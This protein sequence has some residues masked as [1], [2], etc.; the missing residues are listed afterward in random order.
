[1]DTT[2]TIMAVVL[3]GAALQ[4]G[5]C[6]ATIIRTE[7]R[8]EV[9]NDSSGPVLAKLVHKGILNEND[10]AQ[11]YVG[12]GD[13]AVVGPVNRPIVETILLVV[14]EPG[15][16]STGQRLELSKGITGVTVRKAGEALA[17]QDVRRP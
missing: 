14:E 9:L 8:A 10:L 12:P 1:M 16:P 5:G 4:F 15:A 11:K 13:R 17:I 6:A 2:R 7:Y 3:A